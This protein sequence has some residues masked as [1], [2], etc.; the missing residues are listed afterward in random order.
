[1][2]QAQHQDHYQVPQ[3]ERLRKKQPMHDAEPSD[4]QM[5]SPPGCKSTLLTGGIRFLILKCA[6]HLAPATESDISSNKGSVHVVGALNIG[7]A[8]NAS[9]ALDQ[10]W[11][12]GWNSMKIFTKDSRDHYY[13]KLCSN[14]F[15]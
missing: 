13:S 7:C 3:L 12:A 14:L 10:S 15:F 1:M 2:W 9:R 4:S 6:T 8:S 11:Q 5:T